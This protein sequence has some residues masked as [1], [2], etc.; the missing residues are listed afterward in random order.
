[1]SVCFSTKALSFKLSRN[2]FSER[3]ILLRLYSLPVDIIRGRLMMWFCSISSS[4]VGNVI[5]AMIT[6]ML[7]DYTGNKTTTGVDCLTFYY[8]SWI[9]CLCDK[10][11]I[12]TGTKYFPLSFS[13]IKLACLFT[14]GFANCIR[15]S[16]KQSCVTTSFL[17]DFL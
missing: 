3:C 5:T 13:S 8:L 10:L 16:S 9:V 1:M 2:L 6:K 12:W 4:L 17:Q 11:C 15:H 14:F 7:K